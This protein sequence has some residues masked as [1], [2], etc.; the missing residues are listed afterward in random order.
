LE[1]SEDRELRAMRDLAPPIIYDDIEAP[2]L[3]IL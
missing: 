3:K 1:E 2:E